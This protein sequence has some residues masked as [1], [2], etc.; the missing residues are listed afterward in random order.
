MIDAHLSQLTDAL[1]A[2]EAKLKSEDFTARQARIVAIEQEVEALAASHAA[3]VALLKEEREAIA[4]AAEDDE[5]AYEDAKHAVTVY[6]AKTYLDSMPGG[7]A[8]DAALFD[9]DAFE[10]FTPPARAD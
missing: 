5:A 1:K 8:I 4:A 3:S 7:T 6:V 9:A 2:A 10:D